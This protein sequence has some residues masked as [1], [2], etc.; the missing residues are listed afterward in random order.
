MYGQIFCGWEFQY[1]DTSMAFHLW[2]SGS[3]SSSLI[4]SFKYSI[5][6]P[7]GHNRR[8]IGSILITLLSVMHLSMS[9]M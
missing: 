9:E 2:I 5:I 4:L 8:L 3:K 7:L 1:K 6:L